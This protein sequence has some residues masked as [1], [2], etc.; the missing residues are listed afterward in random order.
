[1]VIL[2]STIS[3][4]KKKSG[5]FKAVQPEACPENISKMIA[6]LVISFIPKSDTGRKGSG[7]LFLGFF[8][9]GSKR[10]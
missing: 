2:K 10:D 8:R 7:R 3:V 5:S 4:D 9:R 1:M 6:T